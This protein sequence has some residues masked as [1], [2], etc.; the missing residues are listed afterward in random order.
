MWHAVALSSVFLPRKRHL[1]TVT[2][3]S[4][5]VLCQPSNPTRRA[6]TVWVSFFGPLFSARVFFFAPVTRAE[7]SRHP[8]ASESRHKRA[9]LEKGAPNTLRKGG[10]CFVSADTLKGSGGREVESSSNTSREGGSRFFF[11]SVDRSRESGGEEESSSNTSCEVD[12]RFLFTP[13][14]SVLGESKYS[15][16]AGGQRD[17]RIELA[18]T[19][20]G[21]SVSEE[22]S[23]SHA[24]RDDDEANWVEGGGRT[25]K[26]PM[27]LQQRFP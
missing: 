10:F 7:S 2:V 23:K 16:V 19:T 27:R 21:S 25:R 24:R 15:F 3:R 20:V 17:N 4:P 26:S 18:K 13:F 11:A 5:P 22:T 14:S 12:S 6:E 1:R 9:T 8:F